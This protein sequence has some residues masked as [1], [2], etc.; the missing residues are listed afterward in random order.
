MID[1]KHLQI[2]HNRYSIRLPQAVSDV[3]QDDSVKMHGLKSHRANLRN[4]RES[5]QLL[6]TSNGTNTNLLTP[7]INHVNISIVSISWR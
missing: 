1:N 3:R 5:V 7:G 2:I 6:I 4:V